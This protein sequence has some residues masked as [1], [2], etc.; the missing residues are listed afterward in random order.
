MI[1]HN[2]TE[3]EANNAF[4]ELDK[5]LAI[6]KLPCADG[7]K[8]KASAAEFMLMHKSMQGNQTVAYAFKHCHTR[9]YLGMTMGN[10]RIPS[11]L[12]L[13]KGNAPF[14]NLDFAQ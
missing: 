3:T 12:V 2:F 4:N 8:R 1:S 6:A 13:P 9:N 14:Q 10:G 7:S 5:H 11:A